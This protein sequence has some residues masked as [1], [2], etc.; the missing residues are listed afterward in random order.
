MSELEEARES[1]LRVQNFDT[2]TLDRSNE[3]GAKFSFQETIS[4]AKQ[5]IELFKQISPDSLTYLPSNQLNQIKKRSDSVFNLFRRV[6]EFDVEQENAPAARDS[7]IAAFNNQYQENFDALYQIIAY[8]HSRMADLTRIESEARAISQGISDRMEKASEEI[9][10]KLQ[11]S[12]S[13]IQTMREFAAEQGVSQQAIFFKEE[14]E[15]H[16]EEAGKWRIYVIWIS[17][18][19]AVLGIVYI[20]SLYS[21]FLELG[22]TNDVIQ[23]IAS[24]VVVF[25]VLFFVLGVATRNFMSHVHNATVNRHR[26]NALST[27]KALV[28]AS[29]NEENREVILLQAAACIFGP[30]DTGYIKA[31]G[32]SAGHSS[33][34]SIMAPIAAMRSGP[35]GPD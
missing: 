7:V 27:Y 1:L 18:I 13:I 6:E 35:S 28:D 11:E 20:G 17:S 3:L 12:D 24:K 9:N 30:Q 31:S 23:A 10:S 2:D 15:R 5:L 34:A 25:A 21:G 14:T 19:I 26:Q 16:L 4:P 32:S 33:A 29:G 22:T 8:S